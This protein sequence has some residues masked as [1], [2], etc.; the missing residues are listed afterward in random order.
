MYITEIFFGIALLLG[1]GISSHATKDLELC[2]VFAAR[3]SNAIYRAA[4]PRRERLLVY[5]L[6]NPSV[7]PRA[8]RAKDLGLW[9]GSLDDAVPSI[10]TVA[11][12]R[13]LFSCLEKLLR[14]VEETGNR[15]VLQVYVGS[16]P[17]FLGIPAPGGPPP[18]NR[19][20]L[21]IR[22]SERFSPPL[23]I[24]AVSPSYYEALTTT[25][26]QA[27]ARFIAPVG[28]V[29]QDCILVHELLHM[30]HFLEGMDG[31]KPPVLLP[32]GALTP[33]QRRR[34][35]YQTL[36]CLPSSQACRVS[37]A[38][39]TEFMGDFLPE[40]FEYLPEG[41]EARWDAFWPNLEERRAVGGPDRD[42]LSEN[43]YRAARCL[44]QRYLYR[45]DE[46][47]FEYAA[48]VATTLAP[49]EPLSLAYSIELI[50]QTPDPAQLSE[51][52]VPWSMCA[53]YQHGRCLWSEGV[54]P[55]PAPSRV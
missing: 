3:L 1:A 24:C 46:Q 35:V 10:L 7:P 37:L 28:P 30:K 45:V 47:F 19:I 27:E 50:A 48:T 39:L 21:C 49:V 2:K 22:L 36:A 40:I 9:Q 12:G 31:I 20:R 17:S 42:D 13:K 25:G 16:S 8:R 5:D 11:P 14:Q 44:P 34:A 55:S 26:G 41:R 54:A 29:G 38:A 15:C 32:P 53:V 43:S 51:G 52:L 6:A 4:L 18:G 23:S 33:A